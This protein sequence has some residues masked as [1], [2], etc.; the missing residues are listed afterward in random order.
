MTS[1]I[2]G[3]ILNYFTVE[4]GCLHFLYRDHLVGRTHLLDGMRQVQNSLA[5]G[6]PYRFDKCDCIAAKHGRILAHRKVGACLLAW[7]LV[8]LPALAC[9]GGTPPPI[10]PEATSTGSAP[11]EPTATAEPSPLPE[12]ASIPVPPEGYLYHGVFAGGPSGEEHDLTADDVQSYE[13]AA[14]K[15]VVWVY[16]S[17]NWY[18]GRKFPIETAEWIR[19]RG[20]IPYIRLMLRSSPEQNRAEPFFTV[21]RIAAGD[22][23]DDLR[24]WAR[25]ARDFVTPLIAEYGVEVNGEWFSWN[26]VWNGGGT[27]DGYGD[28]AQADGPERFRDAYRHIIALSREEGAA[29]I[30][31]VFHANHDDWPD[32]AWNRFEQYYPGDEW[33]DWI[34]VS[35]YGAQRPTTEEWPA[36]RDGMDAAYPRLAALS[37]EKPIAL[38]EFGVTSGN[39]LGDQ[40]EWAEA[41]LSD[42]TSGRWPRLIGFSWWNES[43]Q[44]DDDPAHDT[45]MRVQDNPALAGVFRQ[46]VG[47]N[48][49]VLS[50]P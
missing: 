42:L 34:A 50:R 27:L 5:G 23:D 29:N 12:L 37:P 38:V 30:T 16:F 33:I 31:W 35:V 41:A 4:N 2:F 7:L 45:H 10:A 44:N 36:F 43:W 32:E 17:H 14:G 3:I 40:A 13:E 20:S 48:D 9:G 6:S 26:G 21:E 25:A 22:F 1:H 18:R 49:N 11:P 28:P 39:P 46:W 8:F 19:E 47:D 15:Q 24:A